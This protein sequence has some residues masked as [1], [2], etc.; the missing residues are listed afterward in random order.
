[1]PAKGYGSS[2][3]TSSSRPRVFLT[4]AWDSEK[5]HCADVL[6]L[7][8]LLV[9]NGIAVIIDR[10]FEDKRRSWPDWAIQSM[11]EADFVAVVASK[12][13]LEASGERDGPDEHPGAR[14]EVAFLVDQMHGNRST[15]F[16]KVVPVLLPGHGIDEIPDF[17]SPHSATRIVVPELTDT[18]IIPLLRLFHGRSEH[19]PPQPGS[20]PDALSRPAIAGL[21][22]GLTSGSVRPEG[23]L[24]FSTLIAT[25]TREFVG[26]EWAL[27]EIDT[28]VR[29][30][31]AGYALIVGEPGTG[32]TALL[33]QLVQTTGC[34]HHF[35]NNREG[36]RSAEAFHLNIGYQ[37][38][39]RYGLGEFHLPAQ[40]GNYANS[41]RGLLVQAV[42]NS[43]DDPVIV[44]VDALDESSLDEL[45]QGVSRLYLPSDVPSGACFVV[46]SRPEEHY[47]LPPGVRTSL[48]LGDKDNPDDRDDVVRYISSQIHQHRPKFG[49]QIARWELTEAEFT[50]II[51][52]RSEHNFMY[53]AHVLADIREARLTAS[54]LDDVRKLPQGL[55]AYYQ[56]HWDAMRG[57][58]EP[59]YQRLH[60]PVL[61]VLA[62]LHEPVGIAKIVEYTGLDRQRI[63]DVLREW[64]QFVPPADTGGEVRYS[65]YHASFR[66]FL[67]NEGVGLDPARQRVS[68]RILGKIPGFRRS[69][70]PPVG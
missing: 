45:P 8:E 5:K 52:D 22:G 30:D 18:G 54:A 26:R 66:D 67:A 31:R 14:G 60:E 19:V 68:D 58:D 1:M 7:A 53:L 17:L 55:V 9:R 10:W 34:V 11:R 16:P 35:N 59:R 43:P 3:P 56:E 61:K 20:A 40:P 64:R 65:I 21:A 4:Y 41:L 12:E 25:R 38:A 27:R 69:T 50:T 24:D 42:A 37:L 36:I 15:W 46:S 33:S 39:T 63:R 44:V 51:A 2:V 28:M 70:A 49:M 57:T 32:K 6:A 48:L 62:T 13:Y 47:R 23:L 29:A